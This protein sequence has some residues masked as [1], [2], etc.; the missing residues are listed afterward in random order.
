MSAVSE[1]RCHCTAAR[2]RLKLIDYANT[3]IL[4]HELIQ[5][6]N[7]DKLVY[8]CGK[9]CL[10]AMALVAVASIGLAVC[11]VI[12]F[13]GIGCTRRSVRFFTF[14]LIFHNFTY[15]EVTVSY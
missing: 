12:I 2:I 13:I 10:S 8:F 9:C 3:I 1:V 7:N 6:V 15:F 14:Y 4:L 11:L 5:N